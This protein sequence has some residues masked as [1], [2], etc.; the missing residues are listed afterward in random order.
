MIIQ[1][2]II[3]KNEWAISHTFPIVSLRNLVCILHLRLISVLTGHVSSAHDHTGPVAT[4][5]DRAGPSKER[6][7]PCQ[8]GWKK[9]TVGCA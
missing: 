8:F 6:C 7:Q 5:S 9:H 3:I 4:P 1:Q 2:V